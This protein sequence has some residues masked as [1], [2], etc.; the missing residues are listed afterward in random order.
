MEDRTETAYCPK[1]FRDVGVLWNGDVTLCGLDH[2]G[3]LSVGNIKDSSLEEIIQNDD[4][5]KLRASMLGRCS[6]PSI[7]QT[8]QSKPVKRQNS[9]KKY[10][11]PV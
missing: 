10:S 8:C 4:A 3:E 6:L 2:D 9:S 5:R 1:P 11:E 7:C